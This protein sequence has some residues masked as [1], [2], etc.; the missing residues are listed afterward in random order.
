MLVLGR[1]LGVEVSLK[2]GLL[3]PERTRAG[4]EPLRDAFP[5][6]EILLEPGERILSVA[7]ALLFPV[8]RAFEEEGR[9]FAEVTPGLEEAALEGLGRGGGR[10]VNLT[11]GDPERTAPVRVVDRGVAKGRAGEGLTALM[12]VP[13]PGDVLLVSRMGV[14][15]ASNRPSCEAFRERYLNARRICQVPL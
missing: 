1:G 7:G 13:R 15:M 6:M 10:L 5:G 9:V 12:P 4:L 8:E 2:T 3:D 14:T 11:G